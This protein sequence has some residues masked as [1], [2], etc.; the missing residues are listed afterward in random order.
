MQRD[1]KRETESGEVVSGATRAWYGEANFHG[2]RRTSRKEHA[3]GA[4]RGPHGPFTKRH[5]TRSRVARDR[6]EAIVPNA[7]AQ[8]D[9]KVDLAR[10]KG[11]TCSSWA[12]FSST[13]TLAQNIAEINL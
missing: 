7:V 11:G 12:T 3:S 8:T 13:S 1:N 6:H 2:E 5:A 10:Q 9:L 4:R